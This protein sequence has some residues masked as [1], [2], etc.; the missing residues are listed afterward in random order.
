MTRAPSVS[1]RRARHFHAL[2]T[3]AFGRSAE[4]TAHARRA[5]HPK[6]DQSTDTIFAAISKLKLCNWPE[7]DLDG[8]LN[9][10]SALVFGSFH[11]GP[12]G[13]CL[14]TSSSPLVLPHPLTGL[15]PLPWTRP[16]LTT[17]TL[18]VTRGVKQ[19][20]APSLIPVLSEFGGFNPTTL[21][22]PL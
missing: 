1:L 15:I 13:A 20:F 2:K 14:P 17:L 6:T 21:D 3:A 16:V 5:V 4:R 18:A 12:L 7:M 9:E 11:C 10:R 22:Q 19:V 8:S